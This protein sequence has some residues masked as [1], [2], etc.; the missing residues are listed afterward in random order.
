MEKEVIESTVDGIV[1]TNYNTQDV[2]EWIRK[3]NASYTYMINENNEETIGI[4]GFL[5]K[6]GDAMV[7]HHDHITVINKDYKIVYRR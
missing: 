3:H 2:L 7:Y 4:C 5:M 1:W 6:I